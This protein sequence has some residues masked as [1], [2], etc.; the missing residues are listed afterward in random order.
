MTDAVSGGQLATKPDRA[1]PAPVA[2]G[3]S[4]ED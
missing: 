4:T 1:T 3:T 2:W